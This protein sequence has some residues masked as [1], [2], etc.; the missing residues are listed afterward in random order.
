MLRLGRALSTAVIAVI[1]SIIPSIV[2]GTSA[3]AAS[4]V[5]GLGLSDSAPTAMTLTWEPYPDAV[6]YRVYVSP[7]AD[8]PY[9]CEPHCEVITP[10]DL[11]DPS[12]RITSLT[13]G[14][15][16]WIKI[17]AINS[18]GRTITGW[19]A[20]P[21]EVTLPTS[22]SVEN[23]SV[24]GTTTSS[25]TIEWSTY[26]GAAQ[27]RVYVSPTA[28][29]PSR[30]EPHCT[31]IT[32][33]DADDPSHTV[34]G[35]TAG[36]SYWIKVSA[37]NADGRTI[38]GWQRSGVEVTI[39]TASSPKGVVSGISTSALT[40]SSM[41][42]RWSAYPDATRYR[43]YV[44]PTPDM[45]YYCEPHCKVITPA[46]LSD[47]SHRVTGLSGGA[48]YWIKI[49]AINSAGRTV[50]GWQS[51]PVKVTLPTES[52][53]G[54][55]VSGVTAAPA[56]TSVTLRWNAYPDAT[57]YRVYVSSTADMPSRC[58]PNCSVITPAD[59]RNPGFK[60]VDLEPG[61]RY[62]IKVSALNAS[63]KTITGW[64]D[65]AV[66]TA[67]TPKGT[68][69][70]LSI[71]PGTTRMTLSWNPYPDAA[72][73]RVYVTS[74]SSMPGAC[75]PN[76]QVIVP[77]D[78]DAP[79]HT[80]TGLEPGTSH[81]VKVS[82]LDSS[83][84]TITGWQSSP[85]TTVLLTLDADLTVASFNVKCA[86]CLTMPIQDRPA[87]ELPW[88]DRRADVAKTI[89]SRRPDIIG[90]QEASQ[91]WIYEDGKQIN[92]SQFED[93][94]R[95]IRAN[96]GSSYALANTH[97]NNCVNSSTPTRCV[98]KDQGAS[99][100]T[101]IIYD[102]ATTTLLESGSYRLE[103]AGANRNER[104][105]AW[106][107]VQDK[108]SGQKYFF[109]DT[110]LEPGREF[111][112]V[113]KTQAEQLIAEVERQNT[114]DL[115]VILVGDLNSTRYF[116]P[117][118]APYDTFIAAGLVDPLGHTYKSPAISP[119]ATAEKRIHANYNSFGNFSPV[120]RR[121]GENENGSN[122][123]YILT[124]PM[125]TIHWET[126]VNVGPDGDIVGPIP[127]DHNMLVARLLVPA[128]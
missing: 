9:H 48:S 27:Y 40:P 106:A 74:T 2:V 45:P 43:I 36:K 111:Y 23:I 120:Q 100:G 30:C 26:P 59:Q 10:A 76:C 104:Y 44:S 3:S 55:V 119:L 108:E 93:L 82:A 42:V 121:Y 22:T 24:S 122:L 41:T 124:S 113:R 117:T 87:L 127:S 114:D 21:F 28:D 65:Q 32:P 84:R 96:G 13:K 79:S 110:H 11:T 112:A 70:G 34:T 6:Q 38:T 73:Y 68:V 126:V 86:S 46:D 125:R 128:S 53:A 58:E 103:S 80:V 15:T 61:T 109:A 71:D 18:A 7:T 50:T 77:S 19:Q 97:R 25:A 39:P 67:T 17:S 47:P 20:T 98:Y 12:H 57:S 31:V 102:T 88:V 90:I 78:L 115:P 52:S 69:T 51:S 107:I 63:G 60:V 85:A 8:M 75:E 105:L 33:A 123:D 49:S 1:L 101:K 92:R 94:L 81:W 66:A 4:T 62:W 116:E 37:V 83:G 95:Q 56:T 64:Q 89:V 91:A 35:L 99:K 54:G 16:Y 72:R 5:G 29:M 118:N 14:G